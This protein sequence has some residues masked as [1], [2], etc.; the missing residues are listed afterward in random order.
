MIDPETA[1]INSS[2]ADLVQFLNG[3]IWQDIKREL[4]IWMASLGNAY[5]NLKATDDNF[6]VEYGVIKGRR[7]AIKYLLDLPEQMLEAVEEEIKNDA[8][9]NETS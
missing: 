9:R 6:L 4:A 7:E 8:R 1:L 2:P 5:D 3:V